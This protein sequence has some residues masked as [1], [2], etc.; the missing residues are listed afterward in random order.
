MS[1]SP[2][3]GVYVYILQTVLRDILAFFIS[4]LALI[5]GFAFSFHLIAQSHAY[6]SPHAAFTALLAFIV[7]DYGQGDV[8]KASKG[9]GTAEI[10]FVIAYLLLSIGV[11]NVLIGLCLA[12]IKDI[13]LQK[14]DFK[15]ASM[16]L[17]T[18]E[19][20]ETIL[21]FA[22]LFGQLK[23]CCSCFQLVKLAT[24]LSS[25]DQNQDVNC[26]YFMY[27]YQT[28]DDENAKARRRRSK[29]AVLPLRF[30]NAISVSNMAVFQ[31][32]EKCSQQATG[33]TLPG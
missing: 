27:P 16:I 28:N 11:M 8:V 4:T 33:F 24:L 15:L 2:C 23:C 13:L 30:G 20:E 1:E 9:P 17:N 32:T 18:V 12:N 21:A 25:G 22:K 31:E 14:E 10:L 26:K 29:A 19:L 7:G 6:A 3:L 5:L